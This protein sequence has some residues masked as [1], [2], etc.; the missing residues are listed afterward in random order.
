[1]YGYTVFHEELMK[2]LINSVQRGVSSHAY[3]FEGAQGL[4]K[5]EA[6][7]LF[8]AAITCK[9]PAAAP[10][11]SCLSCRQTKENSN[12]D[13]IYI[14][15]PDDKKTIGVDPIRALNDD[16]AVRPFA[17]EKK[18]Y[19]INEGDLLTAEAQNAF[20]KTLE[21]PPEY[22]VFIIIVENSSVLL[23]TVLSRAALITFPPV[24]D[25]AVK[26]YILEK[27]PEHKDRADFIAK[28]SGGI[29]AAA[30]KIIADENFEAL[31]NAS[32]DKLAALLSSNKLHAFDIQ[33]FMDE[34]KDD[35]DKIL[36][37][38]ISFLRDILVIQC[39]AP[40]KVIN[41][42][43]ADRLTAA[44]GKCDP[45]T[46]TAAADE[47][48]HT[49]ELLRRFVNLKAAALAAALKIKEAK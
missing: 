32:L 44:A 25:E 22:A 23:Q 2:N 31:R 34:N 38:W 17:S 5:H 9:N 15:K 46:V 43:K 3:I 27:Y 4:F 40:N 7:R 14:E 24:S 39:S 19:I 18:V 36:D 47:L 35:A 20:L 11:G 41:T 12:P 33:K 16:V 49:K 28:Y 21:E 26:K 45:R 6:A 37:F 13:I 48:L 29:P 8:A 1:M 10:C 42:D 30:D